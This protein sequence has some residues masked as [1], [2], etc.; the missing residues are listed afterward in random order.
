VDFFVKDLEN[1]SNW[2]HIEEQIDRREQD[3]G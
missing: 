3:F 2:S 1:L